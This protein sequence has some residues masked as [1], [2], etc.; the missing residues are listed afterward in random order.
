VYRFIAA[1]LL[2]LLVLPGLA[3][4]KRLR[5]SGYDF[6]VKEGR[7][8]GPGPNDW[9]RSQVFVDT[10]GRLH[11]KVSQV[12][13]KWYSGEI[14]SISRFGFGT[15]EMEFEGDIGGLDKDVVFGFFNYPTEDVGPDA[16]NEIDIEFARWGDMRNKPLNYTVW[17][18]TPGL[19]YAHK[20]FSFPR[21]VRKSLHRFT[22][23]STRVAYYSALLNDRGEVQR[24]YEWIY[25]PTDPEARISQDPMPF[26]IN[27]WG[28]KGL[29]PSNRKPV[30]V[31]VN[32]FTFTPAQ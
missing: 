2:S 1:I 19:P 25:E 4:A 16:T 29:K 8:L 21:G 18:K 17:P 11:L 30:E 13:G 31:I 28:R 7:G 14:S 24:A 26:H 32:S 6:Q 22:W 9:A 5:F 20:T 27:L 12:Q 23:S 10:S 3:E 15:Y